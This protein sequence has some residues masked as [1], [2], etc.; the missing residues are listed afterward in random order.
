[1]P[2]LNSDPKS[3]PRGVGVP[4]RVTNAAAANE[5]TSRNRLL[6]VLN[7]VDVSAPDACQACGTVGAGSGCGPIPICGPDVTTLVPR[8]SEAGP[9]D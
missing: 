8:N 9:A 7:L 3:V 5:L 2:N 6:R 4:K 1:M